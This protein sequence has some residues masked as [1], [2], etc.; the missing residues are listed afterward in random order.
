[1]FG[2]SHR[3]DVRWRGEAPQPGVLDG[4]ERVRQLTVTLI[5]S[6][7]RFDSNNLRAGRD[8]VM[9]CCVQVSGRASQPRTLAALTIDSH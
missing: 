8:V 7:F 9:A 4:N 2:V 5:A 3:C 6:E 1:M